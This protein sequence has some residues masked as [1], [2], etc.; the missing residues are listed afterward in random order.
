MLAGTLVVF[1]VVLVLELL[2]RRRKHLQFFEKRGIPG[3]KP[4]LLWGHYRELSS[5]H[6]K[7]INKW[8]EEF[9]GTFG[10]FWGDKPFLVTCN[11]DVAKEVL[12]KQFPKFVNRGKQFALEDIHPLE[13]FSF[14]D[15]PKWKTLRSAVSPGF[16]S[17]KIKAMTPLILK[18]TE[19]LENNLAKFSSDGK[20][21]NI[22]PLLKRFTVDNIGR[23]VFGINA[24]TQNEVEITSPL[25]KAAIHAT[26]S[27]L[28]GY[29]DLISNSFTSVNRL[30]GA[31]L[32]FL[33][34]FHLLP[35][36]INDIGD[37]MKKVIEARKK[38]APRKDL[39]QSMLECQGNQFRKRGNCVSWLQHSIE[40]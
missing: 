12:I 14:T 18:S 28:G 26:E 40:I 39:L 20:P 35:H 11:L 36:A 38:S 30:F 34:R 9:G 27:I 16:S 10:V 7:W 3:P 17:T 24:N 22:Y 15:D 4:H 25:L 37:E 2:R 32:I 23:T 13:M 6:Y 19:D 8:S 5:D 29:M 21:F 1:V 31:I 33:F